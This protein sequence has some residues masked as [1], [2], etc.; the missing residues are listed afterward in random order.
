MTVQVWLKRH[1]AYLNE[2]EVPT[3]QLDAELL[4]ADAIGQDRAFVHTHPE[5]KLDK[6]T[7]GLLNKQISRRAQHEPLAYIRGHS[8]FYGRDFLVNAHTLQPRPETETMIDLL[9]QVV[10][11]RQSSVVSQKK[12]NQKSLTSD[13]ELPGELVDSKQLTVDSNKKKEAATA[14]QRPETSDERREDTSDWRLVTDDNDLTIIDVG[15]G[16]GC[17]AITAKLLY[18]KARVIAI[19]IDQKCLT[20]A[21][22]NAKQH[23]TSVNFLNGNLLEPLSDI[24]YQISDIIMANLPYVPDNHTINQAAMHEPHHAI[25]G[26]SDGLDYYRQLFDQTKQLPY[27]PQYIFTESLPP[28]HQL[29]AEVARDHGYQLQKTIDFIQLFTTEETHPHGQRLK[30]T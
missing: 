27:P 16:S 7:L 24:R 5:Y 17:I 23:K 12:K 30:N 6:K 20:T 10:I 4:V 29:L 25:F 14:D 26:G 13:N 19:D 21:Q 3:A 22:Q 2:H 1:I 9:R 15:T 18:P 11:S 28:Q 8:E